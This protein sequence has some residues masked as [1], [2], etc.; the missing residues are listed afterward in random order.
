LRTSL[1]VSQAVIDSLNN[2]LKL[3]SLQ[4]QK[5]AENK[6]M[7]ADFYQVLFGDK[8]IDAIDKYIGATYIQH[9]PMLPGGK[10]FLKEG[11]KTWFKG[12]PYS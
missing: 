12:L 11:A 3:L 6:K 8:N 2:Q 10:E 5:I 7:V 4:N 9:Y 1:A